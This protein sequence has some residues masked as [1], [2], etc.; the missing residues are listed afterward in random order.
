MEEGPA[1][2]LG[3]GKLSKGQK[4]WLR[5]QRTAAKAA[6][7]GAAAEAAAEAGAERGGTCRS[8]GRIQ[9]RQTKAAREREDVAQ[10]DNVTATAKRLKQ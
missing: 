5:R 7:A 2:A 10:D 1:A 6:A 9:R 3:A 4:R 8:H